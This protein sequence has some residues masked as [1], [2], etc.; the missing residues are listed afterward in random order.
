MKCYQGA[1]LGYIAIC[2]IGAIFL[3]LISLL[4]KMAYYETKLS[5]QNQTAKLTSSPEVFLLLSKFILI[6]IYGIARSVSSQ[7]LLI[8]ITF[9]LAYFIFDTFNQTRPFF[10]HT[11]MKTHLVCWGLFFWNTIVILIGKC[12]ESTNFDG[13]L[14]LF[15]IG[16]PV[17][18]VVVHSNYDNRIA[19][20]MADIKKLPS[21]QFAIKQIHYL[22]EI[23]DK[24]EFDREA[25]VML[26]SYIYNYEETC[27]NRDCALKKYLYSVEHNLETISSLTQHVELLYTGA[28]SKFPNYTPL[29]LQFA[30]FLL[31]RMNKKSQCVDQFISI[32]KHQPRFEE[33]FTMFRYLKMF[34]DENA[35]SNE[36]E[37]SLEAVSNIVYK[38]HINQFKSS[39]SKVT[40]VYVEFWSLLLNQDS[41]SD[42]TKLNEFGSRINSLV[43]EIH[44]NFQKMQKLKHNDQEVVRLYADFLTDIIN[45]NEKANNFKTKLNE[46]EGTGKKF[47]E[48]NYINL[49]MNALQSSDE[50]QYI[51]ISAM[52]EKFGTILNVSLGLC[53]A[54]GY[55]KN[56]VIGAN[57]EAILPDIY[58][59]EHRK[60]LISKINDYKKITMSI[61]NAR[62]YKSS[63]AT[64]KSVGKTRARFV[65]PTNYKV[66]FI[67]NN[68]QGE[69]IFLG[70]ANSDAVQITGEVP[71]ECC[72]VLIDKFFVVQ[73]F[74]SNAMARIGMATDVINNN[75]Y[76]ILDY[77]KE[78]SEE[79]IKY[80]DEMEDKTEDQRVLV[81]R[82]LLTTKYKNAVNFTFLKST[83]EERKRIYAKEVLK[84]QETLG[85]DG[86]PV[87]K[88]HMS[89]E[90]SP[91][92][93]MGNL[94]GYIL[95]F[96]IFDPKPAETPGLKTEK[97]HVAKEK[98]AA[99]QE[100]SMFAN[101]NVTQEID[102]QL[103]LDKE[104]V[105]VNEDLLETPNPDAKIEIDGSEFKID[106]GFLPPSS[107]SFHMDPKKMSYLVNPKNLNEIHETVKE[108]A[109][110]KLKLANAEPEVESDSSYS[111]DTSFEQNIQSDEPQ[112]VGGPVINNVVQAEK[113][114]VKRK[115]QQQD[116]DWYRVDL[117]T[118]KFLQYELKKDFIVEV[119]DWVKES[120][121]EAKCKRPEEGSM[122]RENEDEKVET[123]DGNKES[124]E[125]L[126]EEAIEQ[127]K[128][129]ILVKQIEYALSKEE[130]QPTITRMKW[131]SFFVF[132]IYC[133][134]ASLFLALFLV[135]LGVVTE[136]INNVFRSYDLIENTIYS[137]FHTRE[138]VLLNNPKYI[139]TYQTGS[140]YV[141]NNT[142]SLLKLFTSSYSLIIGVDTSTQVVSADD[143]VLLNNKTITSS[144]LQDDLS[145]RRFQLVLNSAFTETNTAL[146]H[147]AHLDISQIFATNKDVFFYLYNSLNDI[148]LE[149]YSRAIIYMSELDSNVKV[150]Q[151]TFL[152]IFIGAVIFGFI[153]YFVCSFAYLAVEKRKESYL[154]VFF[155]ISPSVIKES[156]NKCE[157]FSKKVQ[158]EGVSDTTS[159]LD[160][161]ELNGEDNKNANANAKKSSSTRKKGSAN[162]KEA[163]IIKIKLIVGIFIFS[164]FFF[165]VY[166]IY[167]NY[168]ANVEVY[169]KLFQITCLE[170]TKYLSLLNT[171]REYFFDT[172]SVVDDKPVPTTLY[173]N[174]NQI[175]NFKLVQDSVIKF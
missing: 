5:S 86:N 63:F 57:V 139:N 96:N 34:D 49:D 18:I 98:A 118:V 85:F 41:S 108:E 68:E 153:S 89:L 76:R 64:V 173:E 11:I 20:L 171:L 4:T 165:I 10:N 3:V 130:T 26:K 100:T 132:L 148:S 50:Y 7:W 13:S 93:I 124:P 160:E 115:T 25:K 92:T 172:T 83:E 99:L 97:S 140:E 174:L 144:I 70:K 17:V 129:G 136:N 59:E 116:T 44:E 43:K 158:Q 47:D 21:G 75:D 113:E 35:E 102:K 169:T 19:V 36:N 24:R 159:N 22:L 40:S 39:I 154:E 134:F 52:I 127:G 95:K 29:R 61:Q 80:A 14:A 166:I 162:S 77:L 105:K 156:L 117:E 151:M 128:E 71:T 54:F 32:E 55:N 28:I 107:W 38:Q 78:F 65:I 15:F 79:W 122:K 137:V 30:F 147:I 111:S 53:N 84:H 103:G 82:H 31:E 33:Q 121:V 155:E 16:L 109:L 2:V 163:R 170:Q 167:Q 145:I 45:D 119:M 42:L 72:Y 87:T 62:N 60:M 152:Y 56:E 161:A 135:S 66:V 138:L 23:I 149:L 110:K 101:L 146:Y 164:I 94:V 123:A 126:E 168:L 48:A 9:V 12:L 114:T 69:S 133:G 104:N 90:V 6:L 27:F 157:E 46:I 81:K 37:D 8:I 51:M 175:Y 58:H 1:H 112:T 150:F 91:V 131:Y 143:S 142:Q 88:G 106:K 141:T 74:S 120:Q 73:N 125:G 67:P